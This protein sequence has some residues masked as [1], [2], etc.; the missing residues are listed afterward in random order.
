MVG[1]FKFFSKLFNGERVIS[2][3]ASRIEQVF[4]SD[5][6]EQ[7]FFDLVLSNFE[8]YDES[9]QAHKNDNF[10]ADVEFIIQ[11]AT[12]SL[13][14]SKYSQRFSK[15]IDAYFY[16]YRRIVE[17]IKIA[18]GC[19]DQ[20]KEFGKQFYRQLVSTFVSTKG[21][22]PALCLK[23]IDQIRRMDIRQHPA[24]VTEIKDAETLRIF[25]VL[26][27]LSFQSSLLV[28]EHCRLQWIDILQ[29]RRT[30]NMSLVDFISSYIEY[31]QAF[32][33]D[34]LDIPAC[35]YLIRVMQPPKNNHASPFEL[36]ID[37]IKKLNLNHKTFFDQFQTM[38]ADG[39][40][41]QF[42]NYSHIASLL[43]MLSTTDELLFNTYITTYSSNASSDDLWKVFLQLIKIGDINGI[44]KN[45]FSLILTQ[46]MQNIAIETFKQY[47]RSAEASIKQIKDE[48][49]QHFLEILEIV[50]HAFLNKQLNDE[51]YSYQF[52]ESDLQQFLIITNK[53]TP[54]YSLQ[55]P[56]CLLIIRHL[57]FKSGKKA[58]Y[59]SGKIMDLFEKLNHFDQSLC[60]TND[61][62]NMIQDEWL[63]DYIFD[64]PQKW[65]LITRNDYHNLCVIHH[66]N[67]WS[68][69][70]WSRILHL[71]FI[72][73]EVAKSNQILVALNEWMNDVKHDIYD[74][75]DI[76][77]IIFVKN[78]FE[79]VITK[80]IKSI[81]S[82]PNIGSILRYILRARD[83][84]TPL[85]DIKKVDDFIQNVV[86][87][88]QDILKL[89]GEFNL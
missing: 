11:C 56:S 66:N 41:Q 33:C 75:N 50:L 43:Q 26:C 64:S 60:A 58:I 52:T 4:R 69:Y 62:T 73:F 78:I 13:T 46:Q 6:E 8:N 31:K 76:L 48:N 39:V 89:K 72:K 3:L 10:S 57:L 21:L 59:K 86:H 12:T 49:R 7:E 45:Y 71:S 54:T 15:R 1:I 2:E 40:A 68:I 27:K 37:M 34:P 63:T 82:L 80:H 88:I 25:F 87:S 24:T 61:P 5:S 32:E 19:N 55:H 81:S 22:Q 65:P 67:P 47:Y 79:I 84:Q 53:L 70:I 77:T 74:K 23:T 17:Y 9:N 83:D 42:Y 16:I 28:D 20:M 44:M 18:K 29:K 35:I 36:F 14:S 38:F 85:I 51:K 30:W